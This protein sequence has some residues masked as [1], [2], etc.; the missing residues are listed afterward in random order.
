[1][2]SE[3]LHAPFPQRHQAACR[4]GPLAAPTPHTG[5]GPNKDAI[6]RTPRLS[7]SVLS[8]FKKSIY[9]YQ[10]NLHCKQNASIGKNLKLSLTHAFTSQYCSPEATAPNPFS[11]LCWYLSQTQLLSQQRL[12]KKPRC[13]LSKPCTSCLHKCICHVCTRVPTHS[14][15]QESK[16]FR[17][18]ELSLQAPQPE[19]PSTTYHLIRVT[20]TLSTTPLSTTPTTRGGPASRI[21]GRHPHRTGRITAP[22]QDVCAPDILEP[23]H[24]Y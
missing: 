18:R 1:M 16:D 9:F 22:P 14:P 8:S 2:A 12:S 6:L 11:S 20:S 23:V 19:A 15:E 5:P 4:L 3:C 17:S 10:G 24:T 21:P 7:K 13:T